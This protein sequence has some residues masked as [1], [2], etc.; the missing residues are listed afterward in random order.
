MRVVLITAP[1]AECAESLARAL[2]E[3]RL[4]ACVNV[5]P[6]VRSF[7]RWEGEVQDDPEVLLI[8][9]TSADRCS[10]LAARVEEL[11]PYD[12]P[13][14]LELPAAGREPR[15]PRLGPHGVVAMSSLS[16][17]GLPEA[18][19]RAAS[20]LPA[21]ADAIRPANGDPARLLELLD[22]EAAARVLRWLLTNEP[23]DGAELAGAWAEDPEAGLAALLRV[24]EERLPKAGRKALRRAHHRLRSRGVELPEAEPAQRGGHASSPWRRGS[25]RRCSR[26]S[27]R[28]ARA[29]PTW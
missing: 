4:A 8:I 29:P 16:G 26:R 27:I 2:V 20:A 15:L 24:T 7:Y 23:A 11:H 18:L 1:N 10:A 22:A 25:T 3:E 17:V 19:E 9:K 14:V 21:D 6:G 5:V 28:A 13:E 12:L